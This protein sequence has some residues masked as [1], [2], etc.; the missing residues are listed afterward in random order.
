[1]EETNQV[2]YPVFQVDIYFGSWG[3]EFV[4]VCAEDIT[5][6]KNHLETIFPDLTK[7]EIKKLKKDDWR[8]K[9]IPGLFP[10]TPPYTIITSYSYI[11]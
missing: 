9:S 1:M 6:L 11:E 3:M 8:I 4:L 2:M 7:R 5:D 10:D